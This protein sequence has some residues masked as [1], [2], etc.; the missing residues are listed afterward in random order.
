MKSLH[1]QLEVE[2][3]DKKGQFFHALHGSDSRKTHWQRFVLL[4]SWVFGLQLDFYRSIRSIQDNHHFLLQDLSIK[5]DVIRV[6]SCIGDLP[7]FY[8]VD[9]H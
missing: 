2:C 7:A 4:S 3:V 5:K 9:I 1:E 6:M 8:D